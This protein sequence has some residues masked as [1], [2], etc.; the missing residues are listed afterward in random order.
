MFVRCR[1]KVCNGQLW[2]TCTLKTTQGLSCQGDNSINGVKTIDQLTLCALTS[3][4]TTLCWNINCDRSNVSTD[5]TVHYAG[6]CNC[7]D[8]RTEE[9]QQAEKND[10]AIT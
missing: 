9:E 5:T 8:V 10:R 4:G 3:V 6:D 1:L 2:C 7:S